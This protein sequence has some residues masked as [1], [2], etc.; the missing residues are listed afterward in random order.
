MNMY[1]IAGCN[2]AGKTTASYTVL[3]EML[4]CKEFINSDEIAKG[5]SPFQPKTVKIEATRIM[6][7]R[8]HDLIEAGADFAFETTLATKTFADIL[9]KAKAKGYKVMLIFFW[10]DT[11]ELAIQRVKQRVE[12]GGHDVPK[13]VIVR[14]YNNGVNYLSKIYIPISDYWMIIDNSNNPFKLI[15][16]GIE[17]N[18]VKIYDEDVYAQ[19]IKDGKTR[20]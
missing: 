15:A 3:P 2:G 13:D 17:D 8:M 16:E 20:N 14:R 5:L 7:N 11:P 6:L 12:M 9:R 10:L 19:I 4:D 1:V 18:Q